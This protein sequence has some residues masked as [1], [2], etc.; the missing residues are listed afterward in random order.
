MGS[1]YFDKLSKDLEDL[2]YELSQNGNPPSHLLPLVQRLVSLGLFSKTPSDDR[3]PSFWRSVLPRLLP[4]LHNDSATGMPSYASGFLP[5]VIAMLPSSAMAKVVD[6]LIHHL[7]WHVGSL[8]PDKPQPWARR[9]GEVLGM[10]LG[11]AV[12]G[13]EI[14]ESVTRVLTEM[15]G[16]KED[17]RAMGVVRGIVAWVARS[18]NGG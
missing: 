1:I 4:H 2:L 8:S 14:F 3:K 9:S 15:K 18:G 6:S 17:F 7:S 11:P 13:S 12:S 16:R 10:I 5:G